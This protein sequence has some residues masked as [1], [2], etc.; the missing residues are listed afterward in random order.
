MFVLD[1]LFYET[2]IC[3]CFKKMSVPDNNRQMFVLNFCFKQT[4]CLCQ[5]NVCVNFRRQTDQCPCL[6][7]TTDRC[8]WLNQTNAPF[9]LYFASHI[10]RTYNNCHFAIY[11]CI[12]NVSTFRNMEL[13][14]TMHIRFRLVSNT[15][16]CAHVYICVYKLQIIPRVTHIDDPELNKINK[17]IPLHLYIYISMNTFAASQNRELGYAQIYVCT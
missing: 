14:L 5:L 13:Q 4:L 6:S 7:Q 3:A 10:V 15:L 9:G 8:L 12:Y 1:K 11:A 16:V 2:K 17:S